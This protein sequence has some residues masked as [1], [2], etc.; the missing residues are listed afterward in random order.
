MF[1]RKCAS[2]RN[3]EEKLK[4]KYL[5]MFSTKCNSVDQEKVIGAPD[6]CY[7]YT[8]ISIVVNCIYDIALQYNEENC[9]ILVQTKL[10]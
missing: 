3:V 1:Y 5:P 6:S 9:S 7:N 4:V 2:T 10:D 8:R